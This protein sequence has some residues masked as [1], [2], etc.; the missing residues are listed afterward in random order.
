M[1]YEKAKDIQDIISKGYVKVKM[2]FEKAI[3]GRRKGRAFRE[4]RSDG[5]ANVV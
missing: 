4:E 3:E 2:T 5:D 1:N